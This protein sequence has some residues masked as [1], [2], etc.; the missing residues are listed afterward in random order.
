MVATRASGRNARGELDLPAFGA[1][2]PHRDR[3]GT[4][5]A[6]CYSTRGFDAAA[7]VGYARPD[8]AL[9]ARASTSTDAPF[10]APAVHT[11]GGEQIQQQLRYRPSR[12]QSRKRTSTEWLFHAP[13]A[14]VTLVRRVLLDIGRV[15]LLGSVQFVRAPLLPRV[16][17]GLMMVPRTFLTA[18]GDWRIRQML[19]HEVLLLNAGPP[20]A[21]VNEMESDVH[22][23]LRPPQSTLHS[24]EVDSQLV[25][26][27]I[28]VLPF[29]GKSRNLLMPQRMNTGPLR[30]KPEPG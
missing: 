1:F 16:A 25:L 22:L 18:I 11:S 2:R 9:T 6:A 20:L 5:A 17:G 14:E 12:S 26:P 21:F 4:A 23:R 7:L 10:H 28:T 3:R 24:L 15:A 30:A 29:N 19:G 27:T 13:S 8:L